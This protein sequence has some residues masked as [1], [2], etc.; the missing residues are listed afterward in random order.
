MTVTGLP[1]FDI[2][3]ARRSDP[4]TSKAAANSINMRGM[5]AQILNVLKE[6]GPL[7]EHEIALRIRRER[8]SV[9]PRFAELRDA[10]LIRTAGTRVNPAT[11]KDCVLWEIVP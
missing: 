6:C 11:N 1:L 2:A 7:T 8:V 10:G 4:P 9:S 5:K 3:R